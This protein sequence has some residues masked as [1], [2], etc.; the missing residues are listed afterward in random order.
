MRTQFL[1]APACA[2][3][4]HKGQEMTL[5]AAVINVGAS[6]FAFGIYHVTCTHVRDWYDM[7]I[8]PMF[9]NNTFLKLERQRSAWKAHQA[10]TVDA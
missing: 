2:V 4:A 1:V 8:D 6:E 10:R 7:L 3:A 9:T 5:T